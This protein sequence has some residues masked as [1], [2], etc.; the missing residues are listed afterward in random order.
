MG[1]IYWLHVILLSHSLYGNKTCPT[2]VILGHGNVALDCARIL[3]KAATSKPP[4]FN[5]SGG[6]D[7]TDITQHSL[8]VMHAL[9]MKG[10][11]KSVSVVGRRGGAQ[12]SFTIK[13]S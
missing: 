10:G 2:Q 7:A 3:A 9:R 6:L 13:V 8:D 1:F 11:L 4:S 12:A 5:E